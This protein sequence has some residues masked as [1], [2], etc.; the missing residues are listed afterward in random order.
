MLK[1]ILVLTAIIGLAAC[2]TMPAAFS[3]T[4]SSST[5]RSN[6]GTSA[7]ATTAA[8]STTSAPVPSYRQPPDQQL[9]E[10]ERRLSAQAQ[11]GGLG[12][13]YASVID[14][15][16]GLIVRSG[17]T[18]STAEEITAG[19]APPAGAGPI[20]GSPIASRSRTPAIWA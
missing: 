1:K 11:N 12:A 7:G 2:E 10:L 16:E 5:T 6:T 4:T 14:P 13:A 18:Y 15:S 3:Q 20:F 8:A 9:L 19:L 17:R